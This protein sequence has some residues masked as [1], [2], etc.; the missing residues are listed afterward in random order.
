MN[1]HAIDRALERYGLRLTADDLASIEQKIKNRDAVRKG[2]D[3]IHAT[4]FVAYAGKILLVCVDRNEEIK[5]ILPPT[6]KPLIKS[7]YRK[8]SRQ[9]ARGKRP[10]SGGDWQAEVFQDG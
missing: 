9:Y 2:G 7:R 8:P 5:T 10:D 6:R 3:Q 4:W 1:R